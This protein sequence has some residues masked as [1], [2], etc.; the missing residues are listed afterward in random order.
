MTNAEVKYT[1]GEIPIFFSTDNNYVPF[2]DVAIRSLIANASKDYKYHIVV[3][4]TGLDE[5]K[6]EVAAVTYAAALSCAPD[7]IPPK[8]NYFYADRPFVLVLFDSETGAIL[9]TAA[10]VDPSGY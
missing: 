9:L 4:N 6:T 2:L 1:K 8:Y 3:L 10:V 5:E 7:P